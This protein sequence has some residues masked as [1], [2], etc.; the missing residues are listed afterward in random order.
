MRLDLRGQRVLVLGLGISGQSAARFCA[1]LGAEVV[2][3]DE[4]GREALGELGDLESVAELALGG[5]LPDAASFDLV[6]PS[7]GVPVARYARGAR[8]VWGDLEL[9]WRAL[10]VPIVAITGTNGKSTT[11][12]LVEALLRAAGLRVEAAGNIGAPALGLV[13]RPLDVAVLEVSSFQLET[14]EGFRPKVAVV[15]NITPDHLDRHGSFE[16]YVAAKARILENLGPDDTAVLSADDPAVRSLA[17]N[18]RARVRFF[19]QREALPVGACLDAGAILLREAGETIR[20]PLEGFALPGVH[21]RENALAAMLAAQAA[22]ADPRRAARAL[23]DFRGLPHRTEIVRE[24]AGV[25][26]VNDSKGTNVGAALRSL[27]SF[28]QPIVWIAGGKDKDLDFRPLAPVLKERARAAILIGQAAPKLAAALAGSVPLHHAGELERAVSLAAGLA[29]P[30]D[31][32]LLSPACAS[33][34]QFRSYEHRGECFRAAVAALPE[35]S[36]A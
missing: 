29:R 7:P 20:I 23:F 11:T 24:R 22:G 35:E 17:R 14:I 31:V 5:S 15:L 2:A 3:A 4:R 19:S 33:F 18:T 28:A 34:D 32:V 26:W 8:R 21:N 27:E 25:T 10:S 9:A 36:R 6:V 16:G 13:G 12:R 1:G 30:G